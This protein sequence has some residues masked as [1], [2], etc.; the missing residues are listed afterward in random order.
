MNQAGAKINNNNPEEKYLQYQ[1][2]W[3]SVMPFPYKYCEYGIM[4]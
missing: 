3:P 4:V 1:N 2:V